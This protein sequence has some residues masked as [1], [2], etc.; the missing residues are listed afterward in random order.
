MNSL[1]VMSDGEVTTFPVEVRVRVDATHGDG[2]FARETHADVVFQ[3][4]L[5]SEEEMELE[6]TPARGG[7]ARTASDAVTT[8]SSGVRAGIANLAPSFYRHDLRAITFYLGYLSCLVLAKK[9]WPDELTSIKGVSPLA[10]GV[11]SGDLVY[12]PRGGGAREVIYV[13][14]L[15]AKAVGC[16]R[17]YV[18][19]EQFSTA[20]KPRSTAQ[21]RRYLHITLRT[22]L[23][24]SA[25]CGLYGDHAM[26]YYRGLNCGM[27]LRSHTDEGGWVRK[28]MAKASYPVSSGIV[29]T[30][31]DEYP[32][33]PRFNTVQTSES[34]FTNE[35]VNMLLEVSALISDADPAHEVNVASLAYNRY[36]DKNGNVLDGDVEAAHSRPSAYDDV[37]GVLHQME[38]YAVKHLNIIH[39][40]AP[41]EGCHGSLRRG[42]FEH[43]LAEDSVDRHFATYEFLPY[44][45]VDA[46]VLLAHESCG[47]LEG[48]K[49]GTT[50]VVDLFPSDSRVMP[51]DVQGVTRSGKH[52]AHKLF[53]DYKDCSLRGM[54]AFYL[55]APAWNGGR[56]KGLHAMKFYSRERVSDCVTMMRKSED[57]LL[58]EM[59]W[60][61]TSCPVPAPGEGR[62]WGGK[63]AL[64][65]HGGLGRHIR[66]ASDTKVY[67]HTGAAEMR[68]VKRFNTTVCRMDRNINSHYR[69]YLNDFD[70]E[71]SEM[72]DDFLFSAAVSS[73]PRNVV[74]VR[75]GTGV[76]P[77]EPG[78]YVDSEPLEADTRHVASVATVTETPT[79]REAE[80]GDGTVDGGDGS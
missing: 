23:A 44:A 38:N 27:T 35:C 46:P 56:D 73:T 67:L 9:Q 20:S 24:D 18:Y 48:P 33:L 52:Y 61:R 17:L 64:G 63:V 72:I 55:L 54:G 10:S 62:N 53:Y 80:S 13:L 3:V 43:Y 60:V 28:A 49:A 7:L 78:V 21:R 74:G 51:Q 69:K 2:Q 71:Q 1:K 12:E 31:P 14:A 29:K 11:G 42:T 45:F 30:D 36:M 4:E 5:K 22:V 57:N 50:R 25:S 39:A 68:S 41:S 59:C 77:D 40:D 34:L 58:G 47:K 70:L 26:A 37:E 16:N 75:E 79:P 66:T 6:V 32:L 15:A 8:L 65:Y 76:R 19:N